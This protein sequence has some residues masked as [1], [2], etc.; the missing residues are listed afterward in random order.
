VVFTYYTNT[1]AGSIASPAPSHAV[2]LYNGNTL[3]S[4]QINEQVIEID[5]NG[6]I[7]FSQGQIAVAGTGFNQLNWP[8]DAR[9]IGD[10]T[11]ST[12]PY[13]NFVRLIHMLWDN[14]LVY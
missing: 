13:G 9:V 6:N 5:P 14:Q 12:A 10:Y 11:D 8:Y 1:R 2:R 7:V 4:D 3:I